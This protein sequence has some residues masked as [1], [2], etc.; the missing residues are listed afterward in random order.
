MRT[1]RSRA[2][3]PRF[4]PESRHKIRF[5]THEDATRALST[6]RR[7]GQAGE[8]PVRAYKCPTC[9]GWHLTCL[10]GWNWAA[11]QPAVVR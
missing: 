6:L 4:C 3:R 9:T 2:Q 8:V 10:P 7:I 11:P 5:R 1:T